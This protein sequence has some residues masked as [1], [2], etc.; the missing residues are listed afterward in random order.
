MIDV[1]GIVTAMLNSDEEVIRVLG[2]QPNNNEITNLVREKI[3]KLSKPEQEKIAKRLEDILYH[4][5]FHPTD[6]LKSLSDQ[7]LFYLK[8]NLIYYIGRISK[9]NIQ[10]LKDIYKSENDKHLQ[11]NITFSS[12]ITGDEEIETD[13]ISK[14]EPGNDYDSLIRSWTMAFFA[15]ADEPY[16]YID[17][18]KDDWSLAKKARLKRLAIH[19]KNHP[20]FNKAK[21]FR[22]LDFIVIYLFLENRGPDAMTAD[23]YHIISDAD[24]D[25]EGY[26]SNKIEQLHK[27]KSKIEEMNP[28]K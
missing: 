14:I 12:L 5:Y 19:D 22:W 24:I 8:E 23:D 16:S 20:K 18:G 17:T 1:D 6:E 9:P 28:Y 10:L 15:N 7:K 2:N 25:L 21:A 11:L 26:S 4:C 3:A 13:F 27:L